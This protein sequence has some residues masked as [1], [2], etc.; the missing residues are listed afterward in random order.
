MKKPFLFKKTKNTEKPKAVLE[1]SRND[2]GNERK[3]HEIPYGGL[4]QRA[5]ESKTSNKKYDRSM[6]RASERKPKP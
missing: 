1:R 5:P 2:I 6:E 3:Q 4:G